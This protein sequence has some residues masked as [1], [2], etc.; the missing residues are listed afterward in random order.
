VNP[1]GLGLL[2]EGF[3]LRYETTGNT[4]HLNHS[5]EA[6][7][8][9]L[10]NPSRGYSGLCWGYPFDWQSRIFIPRYTPSSIVS[11]TIGHALWGLSQTTG[12]AHYVDAC[13]E[14]CRFF[15]NDL[16]HDVLDG[17]R[18]CFSYTPIDRFHVHNA[19]LLVSEFLI[20]VGTHVGSTEFV[21]H[22]YR[23]L[24]YAL[25][26]Q[27]ADGSLCYWGRD[28]D[29]R[30][31]IDH[32]HSGFDIRSLYGIWKATDDPGVRDA[33]DRYYAFYRTRLFDRRFHILYRPD[34]RY[35]VNIHSCAEAILCNA[36]LARD[37]SEAWEYLEHASAWTVEQMQNTNGSFA[38]MRRRLGPIRWTNRIPYLRWA[39]AWMLRA[40]ATACHA[41]LR[42][43]NGEQGP[44]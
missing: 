2:A 43:S 44:E 15:I 27:N 37:Y 13:T 10:Q 32:Y 20:R 8:L 34:R 42:L 41:A 25:S 28:Q 33:L 12:Q 40:L 29:S 14:I 3:R 24:H 30:C 17:N 22:G 31:R 36:T 16:N 7:E 23:A 21:D 1:K 18:I 39:Q 35:P 19:N 5:K 9:L 38:F 4:Q 26:E 11:A 6:A